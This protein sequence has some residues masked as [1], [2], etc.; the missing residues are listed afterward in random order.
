MPWLLPGFLTHVQAPVS[1]GTLPW[2]SASLA[3][4]PAGQ[5]ALSHHPV[6]LG[7]RT[8]FFSN[9]D[10]TQGSSMVTLLFLS[11]NWIFPFSIVPS[12]PSIDLPPSPLWE[13]TDTC[14]SKIKSRFI[15]HRL[16]PLSNESIFIKKK[17]G[18]PKTP[19]LMNSA[20][21]RCHEGSLASLLLCYS[22]RAAYS[23]ESCT[24]AN[25]IRGGK[26][27]TGS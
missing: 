15:A 20:A 23:S 26:V 21:C 17:T 14:V 13:L 2:T 25:L 8:K 24:A 19:G 5:L 27:S 6:P 16:H 9:P 18:G 3:R 7:D 12:D 11:T 22:N 4:A 1:A 10:G